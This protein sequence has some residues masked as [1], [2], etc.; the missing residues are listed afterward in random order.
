MPSASGLFGSSAARQLGS[1]AASCDHAGREAVD[2]TARAPRIA[3]QSLEAALATRPIVVPTVEAPIRAGF[4]A[5][6]DRLGI[7][8]HIA[9]EVDDMA[10]L[11][12]LARE[13]RGLAVVPPIVVRDELDSGRLVE[14]F[15]LPGLE[16]SFFA[17]TRSRRF[18]NR[19][20]KELVAVARR[21]FAAP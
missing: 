6:L 14:V 5:L 16:E 20:L 2:A 19:V 8:P 12:L 11:R 9:A 21:G 1:S 13:N 7:T 4:D 17:I 18:P 10:L 15:Q 3:G